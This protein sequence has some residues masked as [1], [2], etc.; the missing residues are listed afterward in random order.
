[1][2]TDTATVRRLNGREEYDRA[3]GDNAD[4][5][6]VIKYYASWCR[7]CKALGPKVEKIARTHPE[8]A[9]YEIEFESN[10]PMCKE[11]GIKVLP[12]IEFYNGQAGKVESFSCGPSKSAQITE[13]L[14]AYEVGACTLKDDGENGVDASDP[15]AKKK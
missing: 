1:M 4:S 2:A 6:V 14:K 7:A 11:L 12:W 8:V 3:L 9:F 5:M 15:T 10:K 13:K